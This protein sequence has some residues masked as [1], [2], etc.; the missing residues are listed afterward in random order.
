MMQYKKWPITLMALLSLGLAARAQSPEENK[1]V[2][3][4]YLLDIFNGKKLSQLS[5]VF[6]EKF[7]RHDLNDS[8]DNWLTVAD[9][10]K[11]L[12]DLFRA[13]PDFYYTIGDMVAE[14]DRVV[15]RAV[16][17]GTQKDTFMKIPSLGKRVDGISEIIF[18]RLEHG[19]IVERWTQVDLY[20]LF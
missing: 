7:V 8:S 11:R 17:H 14:A 19:K 2:I 13:F 10:Q 12:A 6:P 18:Y 1:K 4:H 9:Q 16:W 5:E 20:H 3:R 15:V